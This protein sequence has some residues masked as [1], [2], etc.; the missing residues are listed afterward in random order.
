MKDL[1]HLLGKVFSRKLKNEGVK[2]VAKKDKPSKKDRLAELEE[3]VA[4]QADNIK[5]LTKELSELKRHPLKYIADDSY[6]I[7]HR[8]G[9]FKGT[10]EEFLSALKD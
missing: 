9:I 8:L 10:Y 3:M 2:P 6:A 1:W 5:N 4:A 7:A